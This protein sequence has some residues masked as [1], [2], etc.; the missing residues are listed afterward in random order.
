MMRWSEVHVR[1]VS[2]S[3]ESPPETFRHS[4][5]DIMTQKLVSA[6]GPTLLGEKRLYRYKL[7]FNVDEAGDTKR[8]FSVATRMSPALR[9]LSCSQSEIPG[10][11][12]QPRS[13]AGTCSF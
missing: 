1:R 2:F 8:E 7:P 11:Q 12:V 10:S 6:M 5:L 13:Q 9:G 4:E 3:H